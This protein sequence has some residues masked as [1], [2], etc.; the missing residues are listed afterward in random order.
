MALSIS[1]SAFVSAR[2]RS[3]PLFTVAGLPIIE[4]PSLD[5]TAAFSCSFQISSM[6][7]TGGNICPGVPRIRR[8]NDW[9][10]VVARNCAS[11][12][13]SAATFLTQAQ[14]DAASGFA[15]TIDALGLLYVIATRD[16]LGAVTTVD[17]DP[18]TL[19]AFVSRDSVYSYIQGLL[20][21]VAFT[22]TAYALDRESRKS[23]LAHFLGQT[24]EVND[25]AQPS[26]A[27]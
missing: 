15:K 16:S 26:A 13:V 19:N 14:K 3:R 25:A 7:S 2:M 1:S 21:G 10:C 18:Q 23:A 20:D 24:E 6:F 4:P 12:S 27:A 9:N 22:H 11:A 17:P 8:R 5:S